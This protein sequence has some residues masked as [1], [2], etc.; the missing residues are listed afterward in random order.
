MIKNLDTDGMRSVAGNIPGIISSLNAVNNALEALKDIPEASSLL[1]LSEKIESVKSNLLQLK[2]LLNTQADAYDVAEGKNRAIAQNGIWG[3]SHTISRIGQNVSFNATKASDDSSSGS[4]YADEESRKEDIA[5]TR[6]R[7]EAKGITPSNVTIDDGSL[8]QGE[9]INN[10]RKTVEQI[11]DEV[12][13]GSWGNGEERK[14]RLAEAGYDFVEVQDLVNEKYFGIPSKLNKVDKEVSQVDIEENKKQEAQPQ[15]EKNNDS[16]DDNASTVETPLDVKT[17][18]GKWTDEYAWRN[19]DRFG[20]KDELATPGDSAPQ[21]SKDLYNHPQKNNV[22][23]QDTWYNPDAPFL[24]GVYE[25]ARIMANNPNYNG[26]CKLVL[27]EDN[28]WT[29]DGYVMVAADA[30]IYSRGTIVDTNYGKGLVVDACDIP[31]TFDI[32]TTWIPTWGF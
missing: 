7:Q 13:M 31:N 17:S 5:K 21:K 6:E 1:G 11:A 8:S 9:Y 15:K 12:Y 18:G 19:E 3:A 16:T 22:V 23:G 24:A 25:L 32:A 2:S 27:R 10:D 28:I 4:K 29:L 30:N 26:E 20:L 14:N